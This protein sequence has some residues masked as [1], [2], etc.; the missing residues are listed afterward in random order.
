MESK[1]NGMNNAEEEVKRLQ[2]EKNDKENDLKAAEEKIKKLIEKTKLIA[3]E[4]GYK[5]GQHRLHYIAVGRSI[6]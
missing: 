2:V 5:G 4:K 1:K 6:T 3:G